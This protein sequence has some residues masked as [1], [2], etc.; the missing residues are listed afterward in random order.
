MKNPKP[1]NSQRNFQSPVINFQSENG[2]SL[3]ELV[4]VAVI[5]SVLALG[6][7]PIVQNA[8][9]RQKEQKLRETLREMRVAIDEFHRD[10]SGICTQAQGG[11]AVDPRS[12]VSIS[13][14]KIF[15]TT[16]LDRYPPS[17][18]TLTEGVEVTPRNPGGAGGGR[19]GNGGS[20]VF[21]KD[22]GATGRSQA[23]EP[24]KKVYLR[25]LPI[26]PITGKSDWKIRSAY[27]EIGADDWNKDEGVFDVRSS[28]EGETLDGIKYKDL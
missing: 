25:E 7:V 19:G 3:L 13:D 26:D 15:E 9:R 4:I 24:K 8:V 18:E 17:L 11:G 21:G 14:C 6:V 16:N 28:A 20:V 2:F 12:R 10:A 23:S 1:E 27:Q 22:D 5:M